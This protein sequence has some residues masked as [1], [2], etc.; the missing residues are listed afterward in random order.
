MLRATKIALE[1]G[2][3]VVGDIE[4]LPDEDSLRT[5]AGLVNHL[6][7][8]SEFAQEWTGAASPSE[9]VRALWSSQRQTVIVTCGADGCWYLDGTRYSA[10][11]HQPACRV[12]V[13]DTTGCGDVFH[14][15]YAAGLAE[16]L[17]VT[18]RI[19]LASAAAALKATR[20]GGQSGIP[21]RAEVEAMRP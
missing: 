14:G 2:I 3:P 6:I 12:D 19:R 4:I 1:A 5:L 11:V 7:V 9:A 8:S 10:P 15:A 18:E 20:R 13:V 21:S 16:G 17:D